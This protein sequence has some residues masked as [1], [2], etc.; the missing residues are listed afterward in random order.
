MRVN[1]RPPRIVVGASMLSLRL[2]NIQLVSSRVS[3]PWQEEAADGKPSQVTDV[4]LEPKGEQEGYA[5]ASY[6]DIFRQFVVLGWT[7]FGGPAAYAPS[8]IAG[9][10]TTVRWTLLC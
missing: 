10:R 1:G 4:Q 9:T 8:Q 2:R 5:T 3:P 7:A 6:A